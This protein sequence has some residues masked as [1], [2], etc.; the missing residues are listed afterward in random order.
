MHPDSEREPE[1]PVSGSGAPGCVWASG[2]WVGAL[3]FPGTGRSQGAGVVSLCLEGR[4]Q[5]RRARTTKFL[6]WGLTQA[7]APA[8]CRRLRRRCRRRRRR[9]AWGSEGARTFHLALPCGPAALPCS[10]SSLRSSPQLI[11]AQSPSPVCLLKPN[12]GPGC[13]SGL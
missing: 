5:A 13:A 8:Q 3:P 1:G 6:L 11:K 7:L 10:V 9:G 4:L 12:P 2:D